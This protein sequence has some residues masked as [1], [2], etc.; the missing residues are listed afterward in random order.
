MNVLV[1]VAALLARGHNVRILMT[2]FANNLDLN[3]YKSVPVD[4]ATIFEF[5]IPEL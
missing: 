1:T 5:S 3:R 2:L 4:N